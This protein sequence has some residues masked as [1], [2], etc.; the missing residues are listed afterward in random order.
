[1]SKKEYNHP[2]DSVMAL[3]YSLIALKVIEET[4]W[5]WISA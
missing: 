1:M 2:P 5:H 3:I 4:E